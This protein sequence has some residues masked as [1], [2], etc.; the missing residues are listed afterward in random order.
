MFFKNT[1][2]S[3]ST[4]LP[5]LPP[6]P[7]LFAPKPELRAAAAR[8]AACPG[9]HAA[10]AARR[11]LDHVVFRNG[12]RVSALARG[13]H[14]TVLPL[15]GA[16]ARVGVEQTEGKGGCS[17]WRAGIATFLFS[18]HPPFPPF[19]Y[20]APLCE[21]QSPLLQT[22]MPAPHMASG[23]AARSSPSAATGSP[24]RG[25]RRAAKDGLRSMP[26]PVRAGRV[27]SSASLAPPP[28]LVALIKLV[29]AALKFWA[30][31]A[32]SNVLLGVPVLTSKARLMDAGSSWKGRG[33][34][35]R[36]LGGASWGGFASA[37]GFF[38]VAR[39]RPPPSARPPL[40]QRPSLLLS[41]PLAN[42]A[43]TV[44]SSVEGGG[45]SAAADASASAS[46]ASGAR[47]GNG[48]AWGAP[49]AQV[50]EPGST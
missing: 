23:G 43:L 33:G 14:A 3:L 27:P 18:F 45:L 42:S 15:T 4:A 30:A 46:A 16:V 12:V 28:V 7:P 11:R 36:G 6:F 44:T 31:A 25:T 48:G 9:V 26:M 8:R 34:G 49:A 39:V 38:D 32:G 20:H 35:G 2:P 5:L 29:A 17:S 21:Q 1:S 10:H 13:V 50:Q 19:S 47:I 41:P 24:S 22:P 40:P 37:Q